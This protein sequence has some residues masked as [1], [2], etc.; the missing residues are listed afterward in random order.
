[1]RRHLISAL[2]TAAA[3]SWFSAPAAAQAL[4]TFT[5][6]M[7]PFCNVLA[8]TVTQEGAGFRFVGYDDDC[9]A[10]RRGPVSGSA[11]LN[12]D[13]TVSL[14]VLI[15]SPTA[16]S[17]VTASIDPSTLGGSW[18]DLDGNSGSLIFGVSGPQPGPRR[19]PPSPDTGTNAPTARKRRMQ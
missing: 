16:P 2:L 6:R 14:G 4:G 12:P 3:A 9:G 5:W 18:N 17:I 15:L 11:V 19:P 7:S 1:M 8:L 13:G 10:S